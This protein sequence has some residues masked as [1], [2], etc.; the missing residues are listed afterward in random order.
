MANAANHQ[1]YVVVARRYRPL[2]FDQ[3]IGQDQVR[4]ALGNA[5]EQNRVGHAYLFTGARGV[6]KTSTARIFA[7]CLNCAQGPTLEPCNQCEVCQAVGDGDD[8]DVIEIDGASNRGIDNIRDLRSNASIRPSRARF[9]IYIID[10]VHMLSKEAF[11][12]LLKT[13]EEPPAHVKFIFCTTDPEKIPITVL[14]RCQRYDFL[15]VRTDQIQQRL[16]EIVAAENQQ[17]DPAALALLAQRAKGS[18][19]DS[20]SLL[21]Q[22]LSFADGHITVQQV[23]ELLGTADTQSLFR[24]L[25]TMVDAEP[26]PS[27]NALH[28]A[29]Q[30]GVDAGQLAEQL[31]SMLRD[32]LAEKAGCDQ[33]VF[34][35]SS[36]DDKPQLQALA[37]KLDEERLLS[38]MQVLDQALVSMSRSAHARTLLEMAVV[39]ICRLDQ[40]RPLAAIIEQLQSGG[41]G[42]IQVSQVPADVG[43]AS[44]QPTSDKLPVDNPPT[45]K[46]KNP[47]VASVPAELN[48][49]PLAVA[50]QTGRSSGVRS[51]GAVGN[52]GANGLGKIG[53]EPESSPEQEAVAAEEGSVDKGVAEVAADANATPVAARSTKGAGTVFS[54]AE[55]DDLW[56]S[57]LASL[58]DMTADLAGDYSEIAVTAD[59]QLVVTLNNEYN[60]TACERP[61]K[62][63]KLEECLAEISGT[64]F[65]LD[66]AVNSSPAASR[67]GPAP[68]TSRRKMIRDFQQHP[69][70]KKAMELF[71]AEVKDFRKL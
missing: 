39:R 36:V 37:G 26:G 35:V 53:V 29:C 63:Q 7:K 22:I 67:S 24:L 41:Q 34:L 42:S 33:D 60:K 70:V 3:L 61:E 12:A 4:M 59:N 30:S 16:T 52:A 46:K 49:E 58:G 38:M 51:T 43:N 54:R 15:P 28:A 64:H 9:K 65:R 18:M 17:A 32:I 2:S 19:R 1:E 21:E 56:R 68:T 23:N 10:E 57:A 5:I 20:Q 62:K 27:L 31:L 45:R 14:S 48:V 71:D 69:V 66:F 40:L 44:A 55:L 8:V 25:H 47:S 6:G 50:E 13:L 11:N